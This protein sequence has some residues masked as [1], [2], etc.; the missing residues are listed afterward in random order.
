MIRESGMGEERM[1]IGKTRDFQKNQ[2][3]KAPQECN[4]LPSVTAELHLTVTASLRMTFLC[5][6]CDS[7]NAHVLKF[8]CEHKLEQA[9]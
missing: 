5:S 6:L 7:A 2:V 3:E 1:E 4:D 9:N 8:H